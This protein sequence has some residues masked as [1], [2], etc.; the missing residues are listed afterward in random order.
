M[1]RY[2]RVRSTRPQGCH[3]A[4]MFHGVKP[5]VYDTT[6]LTPDQVRLLR[7]ENGRMLLVDDVDSPDAANV[8][9]DGDKVGRSDAFT[10][11]PQ[12]VASFHAQLESYAASNER[13]ATERDAA[14]EAKAD[15]E[16][17]RSEAANA[18]D[19]AQAEL[20]AAWE[21]IETL[22]AAVEAKAKAEPKGKGR[23]PK[24]E[25]VDTDPAAIPLD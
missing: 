12:Q 8:V 13:L 20:D 17:Q 16:A 5:V 24:P 6:D 1:A 10:S 14:L 15:A 21:E 3:R 25:A 19:A 2:I 4:G 7:A 11:H 18:R 22:R 9:P 23:K